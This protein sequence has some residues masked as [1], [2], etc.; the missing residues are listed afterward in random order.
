VYA[1]GPD[2]AAV[3]ELVTAARAFVARV[4]QPSSR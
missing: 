4:A 3:A 2:A 1:E